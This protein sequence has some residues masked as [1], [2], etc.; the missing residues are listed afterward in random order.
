M[1][2]VIMPKLGFTMTE[3]TIVQWMKKE[4]DPVQ[5]GEPIAEITTDKVNMEVE[6]PESG[7]LAGL[8]FNEGDTVPVTE[9]IAYVLRKGEAVP[10]AEGVERGA[11]TNISS[12][13]HPIT[14]SPLLS[15]A[16]NL[17]TPIA[18][19]MAQELGVDLA[20]IQGTGAGGKITREDVEA[21]AKALELRIE[22]VENNSAPSTSTSQ[23]KVRATPAAR[24]IAKEADIDLAS[25]RGS[26]PNSRVQSND[27]VATIKPQTPTP[28]L[29]TAVISHQP[30][31]TS[32]QP[33]AAIPYTGMRKTIG[34]RLTQS[35]QE[36]PH[37][38]FD[39]DADM[40]L[41]EQL[42]TRAN[43]A[44]KSG[45]N[46]VS[47]TA[48]V[49]KA[50]A[51][52]LKR[53]PLLNSR[54]DLAAG[55]IV[56]LDEVNIGVAV[57]L[58]NGLVVPV[59]RQANHKGVKQIGAEIADLAARAKANKLK[60]DEIQGGTFSISNLGMYGVTRFTAII[61]P[62]ET[63]IL[64][65]GA[66]RKQFIPDAQDQ[67]VLRPLLGLR[68]SADHRVVDGAVAAQFLADLVRALEDPAQMTL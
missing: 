12:P 32:N 14:S 44:L 27:V 7:T 28:K 22:N 64:A 4:G 62:P 33:L 1:K 61:N 17:V 52:A 5:Q 48:I 53:H 46:K 43:G 11:M 40:T 47:L 3:S 51:W 26:G 57:A 20:N 66:V 13:H 23:G 54:L 10:M 8:R 68:L 50:C 58:E 38:T 60:P 31:A 63:A 55:Q 6:A 2:A 36:L 9:I 16:T 39:A 25:V 19:R 42:R 37:I 41:A 35:Y 59:V 49:V 67:P 29:Q 45:Q 18:A 24:R 34:T 65:V 21:A 15:S 56:L 30:P